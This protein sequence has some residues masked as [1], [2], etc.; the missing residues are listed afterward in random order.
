MSEKIDISKCLIFPSD[1][2]ISMTSPFGMRVHPITKNQTMHEGVDLASSETVTP[3]CA[4][5]N[6]EVIGTRNSVSGY[7]EKQT[8][9]NYV[10]IKHDE[11]F[12]TKY[13]HMAYGSVCVK[14]G[15]KV[16]A[17][18]DIGLMGKTGLA[19]GQH[20]H[21]QLEKDGVP[22][23]PVPFIL[24]ESKIVE[25]VS[26]RKTIT[27]LKVWKNSKSTDVKLLQY[28]LFLH[29]K[30]LALDGIFGAKTQE[31]VKEFQ[32][33]N[34]LEADGVVGVLT[35]TKLLDFDVKVI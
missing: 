2:Q 35:W 23:D 31:A 28:L 34:G 12:V 22:I 5:A 13:Y 8:G 1:V 16:F 26:Q 33:E 9:G 14:K 11:H 3:I 18:Q 20:L 32:K 24:G 17:G 10:Y 4:F 15:D 29:G 25:D 30:S 7:S 6:G 19:T 27:L 21:F